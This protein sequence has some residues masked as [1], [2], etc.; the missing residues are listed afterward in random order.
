MKCKLASGRLGLLT[1]GVSLAVGLSS[2]GALAEDTEW[3]G[4]V[5]NA[6]YYRDDVGLSKARVGVQLEG[7]KFIG[8]V[9]IFKGFSLNSVLRFS[10]DGVYRLNDDDY[11]D[12]AGGSIQLQNAGAAVGIGPATVPH[13][14]GIINNFT[15]TQPPFGLPP[16]N[17]FGFDTGINPNQGLVAL[18][19]HLHG[20]D[21]GV[22]FGVPVRPCD[23]DSRG[24]INDYMDFDEDE[25]A[26][27][28]LF[29]DR[30]DFIRELYVDFTLPA[31]GDNEIGFRIGKQQVI[32]GRTDLF[33]VLDVINPVDY[34]R[35]NIYDEL[36]DIRIPMWIAKAEYRLGPTGV[37]D[38]L[39]FEVFWNFDKFRPNNL[40]QCGTPN[41]ILDAGCF[42]RG[43]RNLWEN[44]GTVTGFAGGFLPTDFGPNQ[45]GLREVNLPSWSLSNSQFGL[46]VEGVWKDF[47]W[48]I[49]AMHYRSQLPSLRAG[50]VPA[51]NPFLG[52]N[53]PANAIFP[54]HPGENGAVPRDYLIA[55]DMH[56]P[57]VNLLGGS[58]DYFSQALDTVFRVELALTEGEEFANTLDPRLFSE[59][60]VFRFVIGA[61]KNVFIRTLNKK[62]AFLISGQIFGQ[63]LL[64]HEDATTELTGLTH[65]ITGSPF[66]KAGM[67]DWKQNWIA[68]LLIK[69]WWKSD[70]LSPQ[71]I[72]AHDFR[73]HASVVAPSLEWLIDDHWKLN[74]GFNIKFGR[75]YT[76]DS[77][78]YDDAR[79]ANP[80]F[81]FTAYTPGGVGALA[82]D[83]IV[84]THLAGAATL[85]M[86]GYEPLGRFRAGPIGMAQKE[87]E[88]QMSVQYRF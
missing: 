76:H 6:N 66:G 47:G 36:E 44:G 68:T 81:P 75:D 61:D 12:S 14:G 53:F 18:G 38:D 77:F 59:S 43:M 82:G 49:N 31:K 30:L 63:Y 15:A 27:P 40:G 67:P 64:D 26:S 58:I 88:F 83:P 86:A 50:R 29:S 21:G 72:M 62:R 57:R 79:S 85:G 71:I 39:N 4:Y 54:G 8:D 52:E 22:T 69:G 24:C 41:A 5:E 78:K 37:F 32:W 80:Y 3:S 51:I 10:Y 42:F 19:S 33:R 60:D 56:F 45:I 48:S 11:G 65:P 2:G 1:A 55:F 9:G 16:T 73:A 13:G 74:V 17:A 25:L 20:A 35:N 28:E 46:K 84:A 34:S 23:E 70:R 7:L 87:D